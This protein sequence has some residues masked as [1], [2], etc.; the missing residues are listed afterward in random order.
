MLE[1]QEIAPSTNGSTLT[2]F[3]Q[4][5]RLV[6]KHPALV[7]RHAE[8]QLIN[9][10][11]LPPLP[12]PHLGYRDLGLAALQQWHADHL[13][14]SLS[15]KT[16]FHIVIVLAKESSSVRAGRRRL[17]L[18]WEPGSWIYR[19]GFAE[20][21]W[22]LVDIDRVERNADANALAFL[23]IINQNELPSLALGDISKQ[24]LA[25][26]IGSSIV[27]LGFRPRGDDAVLLHPISRIVVRR[28]RSTVHG[29]WW[30][31]GVAG[32][33][34]LL[35]D[36]IWRLRTGWP[37]GSLVVVMMLFLGVFIICYGEN[38]HISLAHYPVS[39]VVS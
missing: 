27:R 20:R 18:R 14:S 9:H 22:D 2:S 25:L 6:C 28:H 37:V 5:H 3:L 12:L 24:C 13:A 34:M 36:I 16:G 32:V 8:P 11:F 35:T 10:D 17:H 23:G 4:K 30:I 7:P 26:L 38:N 21:V 31:V 39:E 19:V 1:V 29:G 33:D 15:P